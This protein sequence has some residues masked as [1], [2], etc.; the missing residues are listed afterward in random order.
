MIQN[1]KTGPDLDPIRPW[2]RTSAMGRVLIRILANFVIGSSELFAKDPAVRNGKI[3]RNFPANLTVAVVQLEKGFPFRDRANV[4]AV[5][6]SI[7]GVSSFSAGTRA[8]T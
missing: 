2:A 6:R 5:A 8:P 4:G 3:L 7:W 1:I